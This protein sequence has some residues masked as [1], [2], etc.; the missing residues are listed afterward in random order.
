[1]TNVLAHKVAL[2]VELKGIG[3]QEACDYAINNTDQPILGEV[4]IVSINRQ[5][6][7]VFSFN[8]DR[9]H[10]ASIDYTGEIFVDIYQPDSL[11]RPDAPKKRT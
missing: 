9:M 6:E 7:V 8:C 11:L 10:R 3:L 4:G 2:L 1:M 5:G